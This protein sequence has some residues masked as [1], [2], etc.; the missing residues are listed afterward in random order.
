[1]GFSILQTRRSPVAVVVAGRTVKPMAVTV[2]MVVVV[3][4]VVEL[5]VV[6]VAGLEGEVE[7]RLML[8]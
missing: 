5:W 4:V 1:M 8:V 2:P 7:V 3:A 6:V